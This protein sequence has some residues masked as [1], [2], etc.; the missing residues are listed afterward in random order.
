M[1][2]IKLSKKILRAA[3]QM[4]AKYRL[5]EEGDRLLV[6]LSG[7]KDSITLI[8]L[9][10][11]MQRHA[12]FDFEFKAVTVDYGMPGESYEALKKHCEAYGIPHEIYETNIFEV[13]QGTIRENSS[14]CSYFSR[15]RRGALY[16]KAQE[17]GYNK[18]ALGH[19]LD[20]AAESFFMNMLYNGT[21]RSM[22][23]IY[24]TSKGFHVI[25]PLLWVRERQTAAFA[26]ENGIA[27]IGDEACPA[28]A[29]KVKM[30]HARESTKI[31][32]EEWEEKFPDLFKRFKAAFCHLQP[33]SF[34]DE[35]YLDR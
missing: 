18:V 1:N 20:D 17:G 26:E 6:G 28:M 11:H 7:G 16:T 25:R 22:A 31:M 12:P 24:K 2:S 33:S 3:G 23:P 35:N 13:A 30:P 4:N 29:M 32:L 15:M 9:L 5:I 34:M 27:T 10:K 19:H 8:H 21:L 14:F